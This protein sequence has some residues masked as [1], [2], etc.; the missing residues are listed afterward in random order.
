MLMYSNRIWIS[1]FVILITCFFAL[2]FSASAHGLRRG[3]PQRS[4]LPPDEARDLFNVGEV[5]YDERKFVDA[6]KRFREVI[7]RFPTNP[8]A[9]KADYYLIRTL[10]QTGKNAEA[11]NRINAFTR[12]YPKSN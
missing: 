11:L 4:F 1:N 7:L 5:F 2:S 8:I 12:Q 3:T 10:T 9:D 6:E